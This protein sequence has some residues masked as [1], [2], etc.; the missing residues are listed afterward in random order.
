MPS[1][2]LLGP[3]LTAL[4]ALAACS[5]APE[6][7]AVPE[8]PLPDEAQFLAQVN[9]TRGEKDCFRVLRDPEFVPAAEAPGMTAD[10]MVV[11]L[12]LGSA[13][14]CYP[15]QYLNWHEIVEHRMAGLELLACW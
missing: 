2:P 5:R 3:A 7:P 4:L 9:K 1:R 12:D 14:V 8:P 15:I 13:Q 10:E 6:A 11:G